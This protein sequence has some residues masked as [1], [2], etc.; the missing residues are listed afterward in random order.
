MPKVGKRKRVTRDIR[1]TGNNRKARK[2]ILDSRY[3]ILDKSVKRSRAKKLEETPYQEETKARKKRGVT[4]KDRP[5][6]VL[7]KFRAFVMGFERRFLQ[8][9]TS[10]LQSTTD[11]GQLPTCNRLPAVN[12]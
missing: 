11:Y 3:L 9:A 2:R 4:Q 8:R 7:S 10:D 12:I 5:F 1:K 6:F